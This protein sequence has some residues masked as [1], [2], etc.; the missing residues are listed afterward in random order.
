[1]LKKLMPLFLAVVLAISFTG[2]TSRNRA[3]S[4]SSATSGD[5][6]GS[7]TNSSSVADESASS[8]SDDI[9]SEN[10]PDVNVKFGVNGKTFTLHFD[11]ND[12][13]AELARDITDDGRNLPI[14]NFDNF[15]NYQVMQYYDIPSSYSIPSKPEAVTSEKAGEVYY[16][17]P[18][19]VLLFYQDAQVKGNYTRIGSFEDTDGL[20][21]AVANNPVLQGWGNKLIIINY[22]N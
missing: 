16:S 10:L 17:S 19:R 13:A 3:A 8:E 12:T 9:T 7:A 20:K 18:N 1:M 4:S 2:C 5:A 14:Y 15:D 21:D 6:D 11:N 22:K